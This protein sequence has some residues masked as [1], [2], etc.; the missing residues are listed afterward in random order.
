MAKSYASTV[1]DASAEDVWARIRDF[2]GLATWHGGMVATSEIEDGKAGDQVGAIRS[3]TLSDGTHLR[4]QLLSHSDLERSY[5]YDFQKTPFDVDNY[6]ST[7]RVTPVTD[8]GKSFVEWWT[9][10]D[11]D[12]DKQAHWVGFFAN[13]VFQGGLDALKAHFGGS[14]RLDTR[15]GTSRKKNLCA[16]CSSQ[17]CPSCV[18]CGSCD[19]A[20]TAHLLPLGGD[21]L[22]RGSRRVRGPRGDGRPAR[23]GGVQLTLPDGWSKVAP[24]TDTRTDPRTL[25]VIGTDGVKAI[26]SDCQVSSYRVPADGAAVVVIGWHDSVGASS[27]PSPR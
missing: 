17:S 23:A 22:R 1:I 16:G 7:I 9:T 26:E 14:R 19:D 27:P 20:Q 21:G 4:E 11:C 25:L 8:G 18:P 10:F 2:N 12:R 13:E 6:Q 3:F 5:T 15:G 24:A